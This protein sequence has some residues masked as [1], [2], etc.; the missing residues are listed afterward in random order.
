M[1]ILLS[2]WHVFHFLFSFLNY[3]LS[4]LTCTRT[5]TSAHTHTHTHTPTQ[6]Y[7]WKRRRKKKI[8]KRMSGSWW[9]CSPLSTDIHVCCSFVS[10]WAISCSSRK[11]DLLQ[12]YCF[13]LKQTLLC[14]VHSFF[15]WYS[16]CALYLSIYQLCSCCFY[17]HK[18]VEMFC[19]VLTAN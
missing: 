4:V 13:Y 17:D 16:V 6:T 12:G 2:F 14:T 8:K 7:T 1:L 18:H 15:Q 5:R 10:V 19:M 3:T 11:F 9:S